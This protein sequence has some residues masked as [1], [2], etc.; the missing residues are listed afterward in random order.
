[1]ATLT[2]LLQGGDPELVIM[3][4]GQ[5]RGAFPHDVSGDGLCRHLHGLHTT[6]EGLEPLVGER[7]LTPVQLYDPGEEIRTRKSQGPRRY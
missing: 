5:W 6:D 2:Q 7:G 4:V 1:M 3:V